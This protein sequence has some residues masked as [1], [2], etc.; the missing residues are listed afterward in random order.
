MEEFKIRDK[1]ER[2]KMSKFLS[3]QGAWV[4]GGQADYLMFYHPVEG[5]FD[6]LLKRGIL[7]RD[8]SDYRGLGRGY[9]RICIKT[10]EEDQV[11]KDAFTEIINGT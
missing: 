7:I 4:S 5:L 9:Y 2:D 11:F 1:D 6:A 3:D 8:C 10:G